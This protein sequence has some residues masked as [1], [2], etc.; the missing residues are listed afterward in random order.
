ML[1]DNMTNEQLQTEIICNEDGLYE[2]FNE[3]RFLADGYTIE[4]LLEIA[5]EWIKDND[6]CATA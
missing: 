3:V 4:E 1:L 2:C 6:E 5:T